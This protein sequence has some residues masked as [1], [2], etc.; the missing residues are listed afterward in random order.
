M[1][2]MVPYVPEQSLRM[3]GWPNAWLTGS[4]LQAD[5]MRWLQAERAVLQPAATPMPALDLPMQH[6]CGHS[7]YGWQ[8]MPAAPE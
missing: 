5:A 4:G 8:M 3:P 1:A 2:V 7:L 6:A